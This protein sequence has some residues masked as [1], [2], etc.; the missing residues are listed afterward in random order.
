M[1]IAELITYTRNQAGAS[2]GNFSDA[3]MLVYLNIAYHDM[4]NRMASVLDE[5]YFWDVFTA[6]TVV[7]Q[8]EYTL[9]A[10]AAGTEGIKKIN[11]VE[12]KRETADDYNTLL[13]VDTLS[14][15]KKSD[16]YMQAKVSTT[17]PRFEHRDG[18]I[19]VYPAPDSA[20]T[21]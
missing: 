21:N 13:E 3:E 15:W 11:R 8:N 6:D 12:V 16:G 18:S 5:D 9:Q 4:E 1:T 17:N 2:S 14:N 7:D 20:V 10:T 19:F